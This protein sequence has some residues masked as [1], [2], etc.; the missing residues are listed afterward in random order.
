MCKGNCNNDTL[1]IESAF[2]NL[3][4]ELTSQEG[5]A[6]GAIKDLEAI[7]IHSY[8]RI[9]KLEAALSEEMAKTREMDDIL[10]G[11]VR[12]VERLKHYS[13]VKWSETKVRD[14]GSIVPPSPGVAHVAGEG[15]FRSVPYSI[16]IDPKA[17]PS[18]IPF[19][20]ALE[21]LKAGRTVT[22][23]NWQ[24]RARVEPRG[25]GAVGG[26]RVIHAASL[27]YGPFEPCLNDLLA[28]NWM[29]LTEKP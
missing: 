24:N 1:L 3:R 29:V 10:A 14:D 26:L 23:S 20:L 6:I 17:S 5:T 4:R 11:V 22:R 27:D 2:R 13:P 9:E 19:S 7:A 25:A 12:D 18:G 8:E 21:F 28:T 15:Q 16:G